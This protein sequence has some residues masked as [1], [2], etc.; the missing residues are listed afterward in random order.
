MVPLVPNSNTLVTAVVQHLEAIPVQLPVL[1]MLS[2]VEVGQFVQ[3]G[4]SRQ[5]RYAAVGT[6]VPN[7]GIVRDI[8]V[9][10]NVLQITPAI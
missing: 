5:P 10:M 3:V 7:P 9:A 8:P 6:V 4:V 1:Q 2:V